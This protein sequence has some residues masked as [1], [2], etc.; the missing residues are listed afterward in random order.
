MVIYTA[1]LQCKTCSFKQ[2]YPRST[3][4]TVAVYTMSDKTVNIR[5]NSQPQKWLTICLVHTRLVTIHTV[6]LKGNFKHARVQ[7]VYFLRVNSPVWY[8]DTSGTCNVSGISHARHGTLI[9]T[10]VLAGMHACLSQHQ[11]T[12]RY[13][14]TLIT[15]HNISLKTY[16]YIRSVSTN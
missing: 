12:V 8:K 9:N 1:F 7:R 3:W 14:R 4:C 16:R 5:K 10:R 15:L 13:V 11:P 6:Q 2:F